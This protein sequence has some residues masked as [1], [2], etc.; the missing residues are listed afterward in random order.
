[1][2]PKVELIIGSNLIS[3]AHWENE[4]PQIKEIFS[5]RIMLFLNLRENKKFNDLIS[6]YHF[7][8]TFPSHCFH[9]YF[10]ISMRRAT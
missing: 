1:M 7:S 3:V 4:L 2:G 9:S 10:M 8:L 5:T 6:W